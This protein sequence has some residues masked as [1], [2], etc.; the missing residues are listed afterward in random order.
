MITVKMHLNSVIST[1]NIRY[2]TFDI[3]YFYL[4]TPM[5]QPVYARINLGDLPKEFGKL[6]N[7]SNIAHE[8][9]NIYI[10]VQKGCT[11]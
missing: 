2:C 7:L 1:P 6:Y 11:G 5:D 10:K 9:G 3:K 4:N 8:E